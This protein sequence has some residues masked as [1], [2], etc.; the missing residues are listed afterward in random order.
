MTILLY[1]GFVL[2]TSFF[3]YMYRYDYPRSPFWD[4]P[5]HIASA[6]KYLSGVYFME[7]H[8]PL[9]KLLIAAGEK[10]VNGNA[11]DDQFIKT[12][13]ATNIPAGFSFAGYRLFPSM[14][15]W[16][17]ATL[18]FFIF[19]FITGSSPLAALLSFLYIF[20]NAQIVHS[21]GAMVDSPLTFFGMALVLLFLHLQR[22]DPALRIR[23]H[24]ALSLLFG[25]CFGLA[26]TTKLV[27]LIFILLVPA[28]LIR[29][30]PD[31]R[32]ILSFTFLA[33]LGFISAYVT[34]WQ[35]HFSLGS[36]VV[37]EL[38]D[39]G[40][41]QASPEYKVILAKGK[42]NSIWSFP[43]MLRD[44]LKYVTHYN[45][46]VPRLDLCKADENGSPFYFWPF[47]ARS[48]DYR[49]EQAGEGVYR[50]LYLQSNPVGW[51]LGFTGVLLAVLL[52]LVPLLFTVKEKLR[53]PFL[54]LTFLGL[55]VGYMA[56]ISQ[57]SRVMYL[58][59][60]FL[61][62]LFSYILFALV[63]VNIRRVG[64]LTI[65][66]D[67]RVLMMTVLGFL[68]F[69]AFQFYRPLTYYEPISDAAFKRR[70]IVPLWELK[71]VQCERMSGLVVPV[72]LNK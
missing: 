32:K 8:P 9:G 19:L 24:C 72:S 25:L 10:I 27:G 29:L 41:Y 55:Y 47:G 50:Y 23:R 61:P 67:R 4:E 13:Y 2:L 39:Q 65:T 71:C 62:L 12:D 36:R 16:L 48:I 59:H 17:S 37:P 60:Y 70:A 26:M 31:R 51:A 69:I 30:F 18:L 63:L 40:Y 64:R 45:K 34:V 68:I 28:L 52:L 6:E 1:A 43:V 46:G 14:L 21:R 7:Q 15:A 38:A 42:Q 54:L 22:S 57:L 20:D 3:T 11:R 33:L 56:A 53:H 58:Y 66:D 49:W 5:Y 35:I 44:S